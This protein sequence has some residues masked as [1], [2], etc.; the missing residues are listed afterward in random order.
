MG[1]VKNRFLRLIELSLYGHGIL[2]FVEL[3]FA[4]YEEAYITASIAGFGAITM[5]LGGLFLGHSHHNHS[6][7]KASLDS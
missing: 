1:R 5:I 3:G 6:L 4:I 7:K 2:H